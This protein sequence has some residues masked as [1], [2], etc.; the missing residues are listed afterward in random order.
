MRNRA[1]LASD[2]GECELEETE[3]EKGCTEVSIE[4]FVSQLSLT[5]NSSIPTTGWRTQTMWLTHLE[6]CWVT[7]GVRPVL[8]FTVT[9]SIAQLQNSRYGDKTWQQLMD[10]DKEL[11]LVVV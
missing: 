10:Q 1:K 5:L 6:D 8:L 2:E 3:T 11:W 7:R 9:P 4:D